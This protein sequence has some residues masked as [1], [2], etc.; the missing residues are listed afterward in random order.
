MRDFGLCLK[1]CCNSSSSLHHCW[2]RLLF[3]NTHPFLFRKVFCNVDLRPLKIIEM[4]GLFLAT[5]ER[6]NAKQSTLLTVW[7]NSRSSIVRLT[8]LLSLSFE[9]LAALVVNI[10]VS[11]S[12]NVIYIV[13][14]LNQILGEFPVDFLLTWRH[15]QQ[16]S[17]KRL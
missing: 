1:F 2:G 6:L 4:F 12:Y 9:V 8:D 16:V 14:R 3:H 11:L 7:S 5:N 15:R 10:L 13:T 17:V